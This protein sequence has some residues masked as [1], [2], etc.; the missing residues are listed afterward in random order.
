MEGRGELGWLRWEKEWLVESP[1]VA[2]AA[3][4]GGGVIEEEEKKD[5]AAQCFL[6]CHN[7]ICEEEEEECRLKY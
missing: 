4:G 1:A 7:V 6:H 3:G 2:G 5:G